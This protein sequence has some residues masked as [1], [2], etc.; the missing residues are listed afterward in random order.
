MSIRSSRIMG[1]Y[2]FRRRNNKGEFIYQVQFSLNKRHN[3]S[4]RIFLLSFR[5]FRHDL[6]YGS[7]IPPGFVE[8][9]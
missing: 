9:F 1:A 7:L 3:E 8:S 6:E 4:V 2:G 5:H